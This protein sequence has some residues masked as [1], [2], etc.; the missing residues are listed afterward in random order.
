M[1]DERRKE[2]ECRV[3]LTYGTQMQGDMCIEEMSEL[4][5]AILKYRRG[6]HYRTQNGW[7]LKSMFY[8][9]CIHSCEIARFDLCETFMALQLPFTFDKQETIRNKF[10]TF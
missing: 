2:I 4:T 10:Q 9:S 3:I 8:P 5:K 6:V 7:N 1:T